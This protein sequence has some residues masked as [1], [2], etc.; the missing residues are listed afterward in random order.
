MT[1]V[2]LSLLAVSLG[3]GIVLWRSHAEFQLSQDPGYRV[4]VCQMTERGCE[5][6]AMLNESGSL[7][8]FS[9]E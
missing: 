4:V 5:L 9:H 7:T 8:I 2:L 1:R 3:I 6:S